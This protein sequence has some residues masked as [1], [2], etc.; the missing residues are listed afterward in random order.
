M[1]SIILNTQ[2]SKGTFLPDETLAQSSWSD[3]SPIPTAV[4]LNSVYNLTRTYQKL[5]V[6]NAG[7]DKGRNGDINF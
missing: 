2:V 3:I 6:K 4:T 7:K 5:S 1:N